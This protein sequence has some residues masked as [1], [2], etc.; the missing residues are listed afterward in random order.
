[1]VIVIVAVAVCAGDALSVTVNV[2]LKGPD[3]LGAPLI[4][5]VELMLSPA[6]KP[7]AV[8]VLVPVPPVAVTVPV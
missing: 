6:G 5:P 7:V 3:A 8:Y 1:M 2:T 4:A